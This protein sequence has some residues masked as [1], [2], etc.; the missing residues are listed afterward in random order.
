MTRPGLYVTP[1]GFV[2]VAEDTAGKTVTIHLPLDW[3]GMEAAAE[4]IRAAVRAMRAAQSQPAGE[5]PKIV[6]LRSTAQWN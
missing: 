1:D 3:A 2:V 5:R 4:R 6:E